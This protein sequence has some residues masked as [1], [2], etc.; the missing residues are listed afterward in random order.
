[1]TIYNYNLNIPAVNDNPSTDQPGMLTNNNS[2]YNYVA[3]DHIGFGLVNN[4][5]HKQVRMPVESIPSIT[6]GQA[7]L[8][9]N[10][11][12]QS[13]LFATSDAGANPYQLT[14]M[15]DAS[16]TTFSTFTASGT[17][18]AGYTQTAGW[19]FMPGNLLFQYG[20]VTRSAGISPSTIVVTFP[21]SFTT[22]N[23]VVSITAICSTGGTGTIHVASLQN[24]TVSKTGFTCN[25]DSSTSSYVGFTWIAIGN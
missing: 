17:V 22:A 1:M 24:G 15:I 13:Q 2:I 5:Y 16:Y 4:G 19:T 8:Y 7:A 20:Q 25:F 9:A 11:S 12:G 18:T 3:V 6:S 14:R 23:V 10:T 21:I